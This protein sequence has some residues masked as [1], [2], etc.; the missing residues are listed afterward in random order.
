[1]I[2]LDPS[3]V[4]GDSAERWWSRYVEWNLRRLTRTRAI[5]S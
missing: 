5:S 1:M 3:V 2:G 4:T